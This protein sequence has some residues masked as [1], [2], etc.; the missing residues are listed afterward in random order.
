MIKLA[1]PCCCTDLYQ[2]PLMRLL[3]GDSFHPGGLALTRQLA[4]SCAIGRDDRVLDLASG[5][6][7]SAHWLAAS[8]GAQVFAVDLGRDNLEQTP[9]HARLQPLQADVMALPFVDHSF[10]AILCE[11][12]LCTF[13]DPNLALQEVRRV[14]KPLGY[15]GLSDMLLQKPLP[16]ELQTPLLDWLC[17]RRASNAE[18]YRVQLAQAGFDQIR[19]HEHSG[20]LQTLLEQVEQ[21]LSRLA[22]GG[23][24]SELL[25]DGPDWQ[26]HWE[27]LP[28]LAAFIRDDGLSYATWTA[29][30]PA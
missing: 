11:C 14:L 10:N 27:K 18:D 7:T 3:L 22:E 15:L 20:A 5:R 26:Q 2:L 19:M 28:R 21:R 30:V 25:P 17:V 12:A 24:L 6:G 8:L 4:R 16:E 23:Q 9:T 1:E 29:R 13:P